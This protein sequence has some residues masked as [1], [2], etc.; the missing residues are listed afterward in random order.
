MSHKK[1]IFSLYKTTTT[2][3][4]N[5][6]VAVNMKIVYCIERCLFFLFG[7]YSSFVTIYKGA[8]FEKRP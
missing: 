1:I 2:I 6:T 4:S 7:F 3:M 5:I 8:K